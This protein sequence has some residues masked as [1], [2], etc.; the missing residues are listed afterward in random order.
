MSLLYVLG[1]LPICQFG[2]LFSDSPLVYG[3]GAII[4]LSVLALLVLL[5]LLSTFFFAFLLNSHSWYPF[6]HRLDLT[7]LMSA[8]YL[9]CP[10]HESHREHR[11]TSHI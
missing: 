3:G 7:R 11:L 1:M 6:V 4:R 10:L 8:D 2:V 5:G 9:V